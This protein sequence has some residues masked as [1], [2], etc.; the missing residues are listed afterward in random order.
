[1]RQVSLE[2][3]QD[4][5]GLQATL[6]RKNPGRIRVCFR[7]ADFA[8][9]RGAGASQKSKSILRVLFLARGVWELVQGLTV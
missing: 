6:L 4:D 5:L 7:K 2:L 9:L 3:F 8:A 1:M